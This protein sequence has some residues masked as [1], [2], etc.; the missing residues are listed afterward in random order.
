MC[1]IQSVI[2]RWLESLELLKLYRRQGLYRNNMLVPWSTFR[3]VDFVSTGLGIS[4]SGRVQQDVFRNL[5]QIRHNI[6]IN[7]T[8][9]Q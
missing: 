1:N 4:I 6:H 7:R 9:V 8:R 2:S 5:R 3:S